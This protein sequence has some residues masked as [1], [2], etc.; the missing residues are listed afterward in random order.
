[1]AAVA[2]HALRRLVARTTAVGIEKGEL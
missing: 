1:V 2:C